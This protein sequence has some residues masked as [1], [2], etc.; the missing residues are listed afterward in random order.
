MKH[1]IIRTASDGIRAQYNG[2]PWAAVTNPSNYAYQPNTS[3]VGLDSDTRI[4][5]AVDACERERKYALTHEHPN[6]REHT[7]IVNQLTASEYATYKGMI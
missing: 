3:L 6:A 4:L 5:M 1:V 2:T 7:N